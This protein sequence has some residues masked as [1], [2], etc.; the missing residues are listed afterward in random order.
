MAT[1]FGNKGEDVLADSKG[2]VLTGIDLQLYPTRAAASSQTGRIATVATNS[3]GLW[4]YSDSANR[5]L[6]YVRDPA[7]NIWPVESE[8]SVEAAPITGLAGLPAG[9]T[10]VIYWSGSQWT[11]GGTP[12]GARPSPRTDLTMIAVGGT[13]GPGFGIVGHDLWLR[14]A[15]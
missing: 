2:N 6:L 5:T 4:P 10:F 8:E 14:D 3:L 7:G 13:T 9:A 11:Y 1:T 12:I 15:G